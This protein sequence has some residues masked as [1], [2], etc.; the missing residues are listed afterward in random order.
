MS[1]VWNCDLKE[2]AWDLVEM[3]ARGFE[4]LETSDLQGESLALGVWAAEQRRGE[5]RPWFKEIIER[6]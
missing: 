3:I 4:R 5:S 6:I 1:H 2:E